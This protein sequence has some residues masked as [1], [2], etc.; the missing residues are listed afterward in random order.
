MLKGERGASALDIVLRE[1]SDKAIKNEAMFKKNEI[2][3]F[4]LGGKMRKVA[5]IIADIE[6]R[7]VG[8]KD[9]QRKVILGQL[10]F[11]AESIKMIGALIGMSDKIATYELQLRS[12]A[13]VTEEVA[14]KQLTGMEKAIARL[15][16]SWTKLGLT[17]APVVRVFVVG[18]DIMA[19]AFETLSKRQGVFDAIAAGI[20]KAALWTL[21]MTSWVDGL[22]AAWLGVNTMVLTVAGGAARFLEDFVRGLRMIGQFAEKITGITVDVG[23]MLEAEKTLRFMRKDLEKRAEESAAQGIMAL[24]RFKGA[25]TPKDILA[26]LDFGGPQPGMAQ[27]ALATPSPIATGRFVG[28]QRPGISEEQGERLIG[29]MEQLNQAL[30][31]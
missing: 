22:Q 29:V 21:T 2:A 31:T 26:A 24:E 28:P 25:Q 16:A 27:P 5:D 8:L 14:R 12:A 13:G 6:R 11:T 15:E 9:K 1:L 10:G 19:T 30:G 20:K 3:V 18:I 17:A 23:P 7:F 4:A